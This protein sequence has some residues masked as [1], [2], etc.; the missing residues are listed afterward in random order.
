MGGPISLPDGFLLET[1]GGGGV[2]GVTYLYLMTLIPKDNGGG[3]IY[4][5]G[6]LLRETDEEGGPPFVPDDP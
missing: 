6:G 2:Y 4:L 5:L 1:D 3:P